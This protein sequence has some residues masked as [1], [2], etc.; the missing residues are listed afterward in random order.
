MKMLLMS[1]SRRL[2]KKIIRYE[3]NHQVQL[4]FRIKTLMSVVCSCVFCVYVLLMYSFVLSNSRRKSFA[5]CNTCVWG[6]GAFWVIYIFEMLARGARIP[7]NLAYFIYL[8]N[9]TDPHWKTG[10][11]RAKKHRYL[12]NNLGSI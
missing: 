9:C 11:S 10:I 4:S 2:G 7:I 5:Y 8:E 3:I 12:N 1:C 6:I